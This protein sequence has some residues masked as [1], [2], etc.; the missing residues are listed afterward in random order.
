MVS[1]LAESTASS[2]V[3]SDTSEC[4]RLRPRNTPRVCRSS[5]NQN[6]TRSQN[7]R[8]GIE[9]QFQVSGY[10]DDEIQSWGHVTR[11]RISS[12]PTEH[13]SEGTARWRL[14]AGAPI[15]SWFDRTVQ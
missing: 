2:R 10:H 11:I 4:A 15:S 3:Q 12:R 13:R 6:I 5:L 14:C 9:D 7:L 1:M 8:F